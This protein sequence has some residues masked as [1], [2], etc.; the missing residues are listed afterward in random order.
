MCLKK[1]LLI[2]NFLLNIIYF[3]NEQLDLNGILYKSQAQVLNA[4][5]F[6]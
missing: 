2:K 4:L 6:F 3:K 5:L 1:T